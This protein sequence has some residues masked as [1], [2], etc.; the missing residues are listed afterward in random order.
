VGETLG[1]VGAAELGGGGELAIFLGGV[2]GW[3][4]LDFRFGFGWLRGLRGLC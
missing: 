2:R 1:E 4:G 3:R